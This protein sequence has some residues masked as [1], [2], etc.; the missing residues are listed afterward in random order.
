MQDKGL[1][2]E[3]E[4]A[5]EGAE[6]IGLSLGLAGMGNRMLAFLLDSLI[7]TLLS[8]AACIVFIFLGLLS[9]SETFAYIIIAALI[10]ALF[11]IQWG[12]FIIFEL[13][14]H[15]QTP[16]KKL[17]RIKVVREDGR[18]VGFTASFLRNVMRI[19]DLLPGGYAV[20]LVSMFLSAREK[21]L[22]DIV[23]GTIVVKEPP[24][25]F[26]VPPPVTPRPASPREDSRLTSIVRH[27]STAEIEL[28]GE[29]LERRFSLEREA[30]NRL[31]RQLAD[32][33]AR[34]LDLEPP[35]NAEKFLEYL[36]SLAF[37]GR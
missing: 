10:L 3:N 6:N 37:P 22:G 17:L 33:L 28:I 18:P 12:Y 19:V 20:G 34:R 27:L 9:G 21:R 32:K 5:V 4:V 13:L 2:L 15:G 30:R 36:G 8:L 31:G 25:A 29:F 7:T 26:P 16:G 35:Y 14:W 1:S 11:L 24:A 23:G